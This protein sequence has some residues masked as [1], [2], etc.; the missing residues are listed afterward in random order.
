ML[1]ISS[2]TAGYGDA[3]VLHDVTV[4]VPA[5]SVVALLGPNGAGK[6][7][8]LR[9]ATG[10][11]APRAGAVILDGEDVTREPPHVR[12]RRGLCHIPEGRGIFP[13]LT[14]RENLLLH[15]P[16]EREPAAAIEAAV[17]TFPALGARLRQ[18][19]GTLSGGEQQMLALS[20]AVVAHPKLVV[21]DEV[22]LGLA[23]LV[24]E[25]IFEALGKLSAAG[26][27]LLF[28]DQY[29]T[30]ALDLADTFYVLERGRIALDGAVSELRDTQIFEQ[31]LGIQ[32]Q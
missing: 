6:T 5:G 24:V 28:V 2:V 12:A 16:F 3:M 17:D 27:S 11:V 13:N 14:V 22:S 10:L 15:A 1:E 30:R 7:T 9:T 8:L 21:V 18:P 20:R 4:S 19:A 29:L 25:Q 26:A 31:Y 23:P 32:H